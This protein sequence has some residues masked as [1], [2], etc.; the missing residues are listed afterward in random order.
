MIV[1]EFN[2]LAALIYGFL[3]EEEQKSREIEEIADGYACCFDDLIRND[4]E[5]KEFITQAARAR[6]DCFTS[7]REA[8][9]AAMAYKLLITKN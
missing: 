6:G 4:E 8:A 3:Y 9:A 7:D 5:A 2:K 1:E